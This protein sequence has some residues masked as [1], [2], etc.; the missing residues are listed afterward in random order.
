M[1]K[2]LVLLAAGLAA[3]AHAAPSP[4]LKTFTLE[5]ATR[6]ALLNDARLLSAEQDVIIAQERVNEARFLFL[7]EFGL[8]AS[9]TKYEARYPMSTSSDLGN[10]LLFPNQGPFSDGLG[11]TDAFYSG[12]GYMNMSLYEGGK[13]LNTLRLAEAAQKQALSNHESVHMDLQLSVKEVFF[14]L[15]LAQERV[16]ATAEFLKA[17]ERV[18]DGGRL[19]AWERIE[20]EALLGAARAKDSESAHNLDLARLN[21]LK[22]IN[23]ELDTPFQVSGDLETRPVDIDIEKAVLWAVELRPELQSETYK[24]EM[25][26]ITVNL[27]TSRRSPRVFVASDYELTGQRFPVRE[28]NWDASIGVK[29]PFAYDFWSQLREKKAEQRQGQL[30]RAELQDRVRLEVRQANEN[31]RYW[32]KE[33]PIRE[34][35]YRRVRDMYDAAARQTAAALSRMRAMEGLLDLQLSYLTAVTEHIIARARLERAVGRDIAP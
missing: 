17:V 10:I 5:D 21:F 7:P 8:Q 11:N 12:R 30:K 2:A 1:I 9:A 31:L 25:D 33:W 19:D 6:L 34:T 26:A 28:N 3:S 14:R 13:T 29:I 35:H 18:V 27:A 15:I 23:L 22:N 16:A 20:A 24:A 4:I 32:Q